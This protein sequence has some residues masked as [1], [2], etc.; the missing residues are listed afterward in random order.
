MPVIRKTTDERRATE[1]DKKQDR[2]RRFTRTP[3]ISQLR[4]GEI[5]RVDDGINFYLVVRDRNRLLEFKGT[6][7]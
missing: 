2:V 1:I 3:D 7:I 4:D 5:C 6:E